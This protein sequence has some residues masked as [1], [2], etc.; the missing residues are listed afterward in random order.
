ML[1]M[2][3]GTSFVPIRDADGGG[4]DLTSVDATAARAPLRQQEPSHRASD[5]SSHLFALQ[6]K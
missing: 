2:V 3:V 5:A 4:A 1:T 6:K